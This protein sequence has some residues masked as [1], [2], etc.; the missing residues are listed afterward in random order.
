[1]HAGIPHK[2]DSND[3]NLENTHED[4]DE[5]YDSNA[6]KQWLHS[7]CY[8]KYKVAHTRILFNTYLHISFSKH[9]YSYPSVVYLQVYKC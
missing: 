4:L 7:Y 1:M 5:T 2:D 9:I 6:A 3:T 8:C